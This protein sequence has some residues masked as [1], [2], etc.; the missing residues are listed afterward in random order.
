[1]KKVFKLNV[2]KIFAVEVDLL[3]H[4]KSLMRGRY[5][6]SSP[7][8]KVVKETAVV[9][10]H[11]AGVAIRYTSWAITTITS[12]GSMSSIAAAAFIASLKSVATVATVI[13]NSTCCTRGAKS[14]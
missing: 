11:T 1:M 3:V 4:K 12:E 10:T 9:Y 14:T 5:E 8:V 6:N 7:S 13:A 2:I